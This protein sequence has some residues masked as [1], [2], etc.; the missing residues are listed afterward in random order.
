MPLISLILFAL[1]IMVLAY[2]AYCEIIEWR[3]YKK[4]CNAYYLNLKK[5]EIEEFRKL[6][7]MKEAE[8]IKRFQEK[9]RELNSQL[10]QEN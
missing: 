6:R 9:Q 10:Q 7:L 4:E 2:T 1:C 5:R 3:T 8:V